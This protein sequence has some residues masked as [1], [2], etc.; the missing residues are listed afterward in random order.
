SLFNVAGFDGVA[1][2]AQLLGLKIANA[3]RG[4]ISVTGSMQRAMAYAARYAEQ[5]NMPLVVNLSL[6]VGNEREG[7]AVI[8]SIVNAFLVAHPAVVF[9]IS[10][11]KAGPGLSPLGSPGPGGLDQPRHR[12]R[13]SVDARL[14]GLGGP[15]AVGGC[16]LPRCVRASGAA[17]DRS[18]GGRDGL[19]ELA[20][21]GARQAGRGGAGRGGRL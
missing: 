5:R 10:A 15:R 9:T 19:V 20:R 2:G 18:R 21:R 13:R 3:A 4:G 7:H 8:D 12:R 11:G 17:R 14:R 1:P 16:I 6:G